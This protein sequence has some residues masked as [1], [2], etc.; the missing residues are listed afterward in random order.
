MSTGVD[1]YGRRAAVATVAAPLPTKIIRLAVALLLACA[2]ALLL[3]WQNLPAA[4]AATADQVD[5][6]KI[7]YTVDTQ[8]VLH[9][10]EQWVWRFGSDS[11]RHGIKRELVTREPDTGENQD[12]DIVYTITNFTASSPDPG[13]H[14]DVEQTD[15]GGKTDRTRST[16][17]QIGSPDYT[18]DSDTA[19]Y[20]LSYDVRGAL[21]SFQGYDELFWDALSA[22][23]DQPLH[24][25]IDNLEITASV[26]GGAQGVNCY[27]GP[28]QSRNACTSKDVSGQDAVFGQTDLPAGDGV[29]IG[30]KI[31]SGL[32][33]D[34]T[35][36]LERKAGIASVL[37]SPGVLIPGIVLLVIT[38]GMPI[39]GY[40]IAKSRSTDLRY[41]DLPP[42]TVPLAGA[43]A[44]VGKSDPRLQIPV[45]FTPPPIPVAQA[46]ILVDGQ[47]DVR[48]TAATLI[49]LAVRGA[50]KIDN[51]D[52]DGP[53]V[54]LLD[55]NKAAAPHQTALLTEI[56]GGRPP[57]ARTDLS[58]RGSMT[59]A[60]K[61]MVQRIRSEVAQL[62]WF[63]N[64]PKA[65]GRSAFGGVFAFAVMAGIFI[66][67]AGATSV[68]FLLAIPVASLVLTIAL[69][70]RILRRGQRT[71]NGRAICDHVDGFKQYLAT[72]EA[73]QLRFEEGEDI[74]SKYLPW[75][76]AFDLAD[77][78]QR[79]CERLVEMGRMPDRTP[80]WYSGYGN[81][82]T[83]FNV[84][85]L[86]GS[87]TTA[88][89]PASSSG[90]FGSGSGGTGFGSGGSSFSGGGF[91]GGG[92]GGGGASSW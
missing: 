43:D 54:E 17:Y 48:D 21:R 5:N 51:S 72:A 85:Y 62:G 24:P 38:A 64:V 67:H 28:V 6:L 27:A 73:D 9:V 45:A 31:K 49:D 50:I 46:G 44:R 69:V 60:H 89:T 14:T 82:F 84:G 79:I 15:N 59:E 37:L 19:T 41:L 83:A 26:P 33:A 68:I 63:T 86:T 78:W 1:P 42:G 34:A 76:I 90:G 55:P 4:Q 13:V 35:P 22:S 71:P 57:G 39:V 47:V 92:G 29:T 58:S 3:T 88:A 66:F 81:G 32:V 30:V 36:D 10:K 2:G 25:L 56:F 12:K 65:A 61:T 20:D 52:G 23:T 11:G 75:A 70:S 74:F 87:L 80:Y 18:V 77:R 91:S 8:G 53:V 40:L 16:T 7:N